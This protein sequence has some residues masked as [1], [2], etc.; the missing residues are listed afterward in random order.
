MKCHCTVERR[1]YPANGLQVLGAII[2]CTNE[3]GVTKADLATLAAQSGLSESTVRRYL[4]MFVED[5]VMEIKKR[6]WQQPNTIS[7][8]TNQTL[9][10]DKVY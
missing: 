9:C 4:K 2:R 5:G 8:L 10:N 1:Y 3:E 6:G 7:L